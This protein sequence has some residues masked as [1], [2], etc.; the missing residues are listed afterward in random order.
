VNVVG[1]LQS[2]PAGSSAVTGR[3]VTDLEAT[4]LASRS[5]GP[6][7]PG[8]NAVID[9]QC[10]PQTTPIPGNDAQPSHGQRNLG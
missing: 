1:P 10:R 6:L 9:K 8:S 3:S 4:I 2:P 7:G 5:K